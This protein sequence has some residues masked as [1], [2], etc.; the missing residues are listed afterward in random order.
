MTQFIIALLSAVLPLGY[1]LSLL[2][3]KPFLPENVM[4]F[5]VIPAIIMLHIVLRRILSIP[6]LHVFL[7]IAYAAFFTFYQTFSN[8]TPFLC[9]L[10][11]LHGLALIAVSLTFPLENT[12]EGQTTDEG[13][14]DKEEQAK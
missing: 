4:S 2:A 11:T 12:T 6:P 8:G 14:E 5:G 3:E 9:A 13:T 7:L 1:Y 10:I